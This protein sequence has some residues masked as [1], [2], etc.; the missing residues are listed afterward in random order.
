MKALQV[1]RNMLRLYGEKRIPRA[2]AA[3]SYYLT[4]TG[5]P[6]LICL[7]SLLGNNYARAM[8]IVEFLDE[9][10]SAE[11]TRTIRSF[12][13]YVA[14]SHSSAMFFAGLMVVLTSASAAVRNLQATIG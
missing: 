9:F 10:M 6:L 7:Y 2:A 4:M 14:R 11:T 8:Q 5:F 13:N 1:G 12:M 3:L